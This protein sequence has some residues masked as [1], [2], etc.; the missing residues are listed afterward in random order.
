MAKKKIKRSSLIKTLL[1][2]IASTIILINVVQLLFIT[3]DS[4]SSIIESKTKDYID[5]SDSLASSIENNINSIL[6]ELNTYVDADIMKDRNMPEI[7]KWLIDHEK[8]RSK[9]FDYI[10]IAGADGTAHTDMGTTVGVSS[11]LTIRKFTEGK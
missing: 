3:K 11:V 6:N 10:L 8:I 2:S 7:Y 5:L 1:L 4:K 9:H